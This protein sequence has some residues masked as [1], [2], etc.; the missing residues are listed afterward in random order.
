VLAGPAHTELELTA[1]ITSLDAPVHRVA[2]SVR[3]DLAGS[4]DT[5]L[6]ADLPHGQTGAGAAGYAAVV[7][8]TGPGL[9]ARATTAFDVAPHWSDAPRYGFLSDFGP[10]E[11][12]AESN[13]RLDVMLKLHLNVVQFYDWMPNHYRL[14]PE[15]LEYTDSLGRRLS[16]A[17]VERKVALC[18]ERGMAAL[19]YGALYGA[20]WEFS[21]SHPDWLLYDG[22]RQRLHLAERF[23]LQDISAGSPWRAWILGQYERVLQELAFDGIH[24]D[25]YGFPKRALSRVGGT[26]HA[27]DLAAEFP[28]FVEAACARLR[29]LRPGGGSIFNCVNAWPLDAMPQVRSD[30][31]TYIEVWEPHESYRDLYELIRR[32][33]LLRAD[34]AVVLAAYL[35]SFHPDA[36]R[37]EGALAAFRLAFAVIAASGGSHL[38]AGEGEGLLAEAYY[39]RH[40]RLIEPEL[41]IV[42]RYV[43]FAV[44][45]VE[46]FLGGGTVDHAWTDV[47]PTNGVI[48]LEHS[49]LGSYGAGARP[50]SLWTVVRRHGS[51]TVLHL[52]NLPADDRWNASHAEPE[53]I[54]DLIV[55]V[56]VTDQ[57]AAASWDTPDDEV[58]VARPL[59]VKLTA[60][61]DGPELVLT[62]P[63]VATWTT[64]WWDASE[65]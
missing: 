48:V 54:A 22:A 8:A 11:T 27:V 59:A 10:D 15:T 26:W 49:R 38:I 29:Q 16:R 58:G 55:R 52:I 14:V 19:A 64:A 18:H 50:G 7:R 9:A 28:S 23:Y 33:R 51:R 17:V 60:G 43:D 44:R 56:R 21:E 61:P 47:G 13:R 24:I 12:P 6:S 41:A 30:A 5:I 25:Q 35:R 37:P 53:P 2:A 45:N 3:T 1:E 4:V 42:R 31:A 62:V 63:S 65:P 40:G 57:P 20:E 34:K 32:A 36:P 39:P 46:L